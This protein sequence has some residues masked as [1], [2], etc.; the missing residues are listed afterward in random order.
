[1]GTYESKYASFRQ[2]YDGAE[3]DIMGEAAGIAHASE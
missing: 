1:M 3:E 2:A